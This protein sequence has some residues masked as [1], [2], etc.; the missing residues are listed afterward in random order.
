[1]AGDLAVQGMGLKA[2]KYG[3]IVRR[4]GKHFHI[5]FPDCPGCQTVTTEKGNIGRVAKEA[6]IGWLEAS[7][8]TSNPALRFPHAITV[9]EDEEAR[10]VPVSVSLEEKI[11]QAKR[12]R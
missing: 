7:V 1:V 10:W 2:M 8:E 9:R 12:K 4:E 11:I 6:L 5:H 3:A